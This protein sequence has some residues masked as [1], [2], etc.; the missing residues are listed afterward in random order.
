MFQH[1]FRWCFVARA[2]NGGA[3]GTKSESAP[4]CLPFVR[5]AGYVPVRSVVLVRSFFNRSCAHPPSR[6]KTPASRM[7]FR[8]GQGRI[9]M[10]CRWLTGRA[11]RIAMAKNELPHTGQQHF[12]HG[13]ARLFVRCRSLLGSVRCDDLAVNEKIPESGKSGARSER[14]F[15]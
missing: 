8:C 15:G 2:S 11:V 10:P 12:C 4:R 5:A 14:C 9:Q 3:F 7:A 13:H 6:T 1:D